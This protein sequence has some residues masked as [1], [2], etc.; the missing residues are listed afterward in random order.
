MAKAFLASLLLIVVLVP[1][2]HSAEPNAV[3]V[4]WLGDAAPATT[5]G[6]SFGVPWPRGAIRK[7]EALHIVDS[8]GHAIPSQT[9]PLAYWPDGSM[10]WT[11]HALL[12][13]AETG[14][15]FTIEPGEIGAP[16]MP[17]TVVDS[18][19]SIT[20][21]TGALTAQLKK[22]GAQLISSISIG[23][24]LI[25]SNGTLVCTLEDRSQY[26]TQ[27]TLREE[28]FASQIDSVNVEQSGPV[29]AVVKITGKHKSLGGDRAW[30][31]FIVR[32]YFF[33]GSDS[34][35]IVH[36][37]IFDGDE[38]K[39]FIKGLGIRFDVPMREQFHNRHMR[40]AGETGIFAES[41]QLISGRRFAGPGLYQKQ[42]EGKPL[43]NVA[44]LPRGQLVQEMAVW[45]A[46]KLVQISPD[47]YT[48]LKRTNDKSSWIRSTGGTRS[49]GAA[50]VGDVDGGLSLAMKNFWQESP[51]ELEI[52]GASTDTAHL[53][54]WLWSP[55]SPAMDMRHYDTKGHGLE[56]SYED[57]QPGFSSAMGVA[58][59][60]ELT[61]RALGQVPAN[62]ELLN[63]AKA[64]ATP[65][66]LVCAP[67]YYHSIPVLGVWS[68]P[69]RSTPG[70][71]WIE[72]QLDKA[73]TFY[74]SQIEQRR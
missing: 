30:L 50:F 1:I 71:A 43:P 21:S 45:D 41:V 29:R 48:I 10:K 15:P 59:T 42:I 3:Q 66:H 7:G 17:V 49:I 12:A 35:R 57:Y 6:V 38:Q 64:V 54:L 2:A 16:Q 69:D 53:T 36:T 18:A 26:E 25:A 9:W 22:T 70:K 51:T 55:D 73:I 8:M 14:G 52:T 32:L 4:D 31:P 23:D 40:F 24:K 62:L 67:E 13:D 27:R 11:G 47:S 33:A 58:R 61:V 19:D 5:Q 74:Q 28:D 46:Y 44:D 56:A 60:S 20:I 68:L 37:I 65:P 39:D 72:D 34:I 63:F